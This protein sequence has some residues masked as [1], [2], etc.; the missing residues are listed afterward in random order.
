VAH[1]C[2]LSNSGGRDQVQ[3]QP[4]QIVLKALTQKTHHNKGMAQGIDPEFKPQYCKEKEKEKRKKP[5]LYSA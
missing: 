2:N 1:A 4:G 3:S 5:A